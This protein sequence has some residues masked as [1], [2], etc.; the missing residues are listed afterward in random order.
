M[1]NEET[2]GHRL[3]GLSELLV[4]AVEELFES[5]EVAKRFSH[6]LTVDGNHIVVHPVVNGIVTTGSHRLSYFALVVREHKVHA[7]A[8][9]I[10]F[11]AEVFC[12]HGRA[13]QVP[14]RE[15]VAPRRRPTH[16][17]FGSS[18][19]PER[20]VGGIALFALTVELAS[21]AE[22]FFHITARKFAVAMVLVVFGNVEINVS[23]AFVG[24][25][26]VDDAFHIFNLFDDMTAGMRFDAWREHIER[27]HSLV[28]A[29]EIEL[30]HFHRLELFEASLLCDFVFALIGIVL[31]VAHVGDIAHIAHLVTEGSEI[32]IEHVEGD[33]RTSVTEVWV[34]INRRTAHIHTHTSLVNRL[35]RHLGACEGVEDEKCIIVSHF[36]FDVKLFLLTCEKM[37][38]A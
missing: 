9:D 11:L 7:A 24:I 22:E 25:A 30:H 16:N 15:S 8:V 6:L 3:V 19:F 10:K 38:Y 28:I 34:A 13:L 36:I 29:I 2:N 21:G 35:E 17:V 18:L 37:S 12:A 5:D 32:A 4:R 1:K 27:F 31:Q 20:E 23:V 26:R 14:T 33:G